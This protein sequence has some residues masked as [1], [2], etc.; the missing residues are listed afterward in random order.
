VKRTAILLVTICLLTPAGC[1]R[2]SN[3][4]SVAQPDEN[5][6]A[7]DRLLEGMRVRLDLM[8]TVARVKWNSKAAIFDPERERALLDDVVA[9]GRSYQLDQ[10]LTRSFFAAQMEAAKLVQQEDFDQWKAAIQPP[11]DDVPDLAVLRKQIDAINGEL[12]ES[13]GHAMAALKSTD[14]QQRLE[15]KTIEV[16]AGISRPTREAALKPLRRE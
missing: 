9:R 8:H 4:T 3:A 15:G 7:L 1:G 2:R 14:G 13:L 10:D 5:Q 6:A 11:F 16:F 12:L